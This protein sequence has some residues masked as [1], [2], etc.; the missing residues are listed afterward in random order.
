MLS[1]EKQGGE[2]CLVLTGMRHFEKLHISQDLHARNLWG[3]LPNFLATSLL[4][5]GFDSASD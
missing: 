2:A 5:S 1:G 4:V 3:L